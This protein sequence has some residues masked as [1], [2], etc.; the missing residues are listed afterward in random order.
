[1]ND[2]EV[3]YTVWYGGYVYDRFGHYTPAFLIAVLALCG[4]IG[5]FWLAT[6][7]LEAP[8]RIA[9]GDD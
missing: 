6:R 2:C 1:M 9:M 8:Y 7:R 5:C 3:L 4:V